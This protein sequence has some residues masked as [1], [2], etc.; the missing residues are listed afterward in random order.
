MASTGQTQA[1]EDIRLDIAE[2][3]ELATKATRTAVRNVL[4]Q[5]IEKREKQLAALV[6]AEARAKAVAEAKV[7][8][9]EKS[10]SAASSAVIYKTVDSYSWNQEDNKIRLAKKFV[11]NI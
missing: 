11:L 9:A 1:Q 7:A 2:L 6:Q 3:Q 8:N 4:N 5:E 10:K